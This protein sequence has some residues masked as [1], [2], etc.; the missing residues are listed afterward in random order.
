MFEPDYSAGR[1]FLEIPS[2]YRY[3]EKF[4]TWVL[5]Y[6]EVRLFQFLYRQKALPR[7]LSDDDKNDAI[8]PPIS[9][10]CDFEHICV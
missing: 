7:E 1:V 5:L 9:K 8:L 10:F 4:W 6:F 2:S 3:F